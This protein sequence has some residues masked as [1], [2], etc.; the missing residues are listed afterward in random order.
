MFHVDNTNINMIRTTVPLAVRINT[1]SVLVS[2]LTGQIT[3]VPR[4]N[5][6]A[7]QQCKVRGEKGKWATVQEAA[8]SM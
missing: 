8:H 6:M 7:E 3:I 1:S 5:K 2:Q 4:R